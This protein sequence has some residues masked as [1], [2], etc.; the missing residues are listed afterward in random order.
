[1]FR[2][3]II[4]LIPA[5]IIAFIQVKY[6]WPRSDLNHIEIS[7]EYLKDSN[8][9]LKI[10]ELIMAS[11]IVMIIQL[12][13][14]IDPLTQNLIVLSLFRTIGYVFII[15]GLIVSL[16]SLKTIGNNWAGLA[17]Y[18][19]K[20]NQKLVVNG[21]YRYMRHPIYTAVL[22]EMTGYQ[23]LV[24]SW[25]SPFILIPLYIFFKRHIELEEKLL[26]QKYSNQYMK[27]K[28]QTKSLIP[29]IF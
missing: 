6:I 17:E 7:G 26:I 22:L 3:D 18:Q 29:F 8:R 1:M 4:Y 15:T 9:K 2:P 14:Q 10:H 23:L 5:V 21:I 12:C 27:Y 13:F 16:I 20:K 24:N 28:T 25:L 11:Y 19:I